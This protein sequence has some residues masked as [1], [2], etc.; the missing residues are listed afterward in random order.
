MASHTTSVVVVEDD[1]DI[2]EALIAIVESR[3]VA[4]RA[5]RDGA[6][7]LDLVRASPPPDAVFLDRWLPK[8]DGA[9]VLATMKSDPALSTIPIVWMS[10]D[11]ECPAAAARHLAKPFDVDALLEAL[12]SVCTT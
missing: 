3:G 12:C 7:A 5:A 8:L 9:A 6:E 11:P 4:V 10:A 2:R 1:I